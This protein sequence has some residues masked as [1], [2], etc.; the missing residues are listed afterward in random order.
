MSAHH[1]GSPASLFL[2]QEQSIIVRGGATSPLCNLHWKF[3]RL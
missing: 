1:F 2:L 3:G